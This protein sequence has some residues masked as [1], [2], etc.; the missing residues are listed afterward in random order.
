MARF[1]REALIDRALAALN[2]A[3]TRAVEA[4]FEPDKA[5]TFVFSFLQA[6]LPS[7]AVLPNLWKEMK[8]PLVRNASADFGRRQ[9]INNLT[10]NVFHQ[11]GR[12]RR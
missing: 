9:T 8:S 11:L 7:K 3:A 5:L 4:P 1:D 6:E 12:T 10:A 2:E